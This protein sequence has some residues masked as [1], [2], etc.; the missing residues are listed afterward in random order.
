[1]SKIP[2]LAELMKAGAH[3]GHQKSKWHPKM[4]PYIFTVKN[5]IHIINLEETQ[6]QLEK[7]LA[8]VKQ[9]VTAGGTVLFV[10]TKDQAKAPIR[11]AAVSCGMPYIVSRWLGGTLTNASTILNLVK[12]YRK[13]KS[14]QTTGELEKYTKR[15]QLSIVREI[16]KLDEMI[17]GIESLEKIPD[18]IFV[19]DIRKEKT[20]IM[21]AIKKNV[22][23][24]AVV[25]TNVNPELVAYPIPC[26]DDASNAIK[27]ISNVLAEAIN[28]AKAEAK[29]LKPENKK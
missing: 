12:K 19:W 11:E 2:E 28:E 14:D 17:G 25:D 22:P 1:M 26:N 4:E 20:A 8:F 24:V 6:K 21:E 29:T 15:E 23:V 27:L 9:T 16:A 3:F 5:G 10:G 13:L 18:I 7:A